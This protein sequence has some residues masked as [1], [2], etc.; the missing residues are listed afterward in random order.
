[1][2]SVSFLAVA[3][4]SQPLPGQAAPEPV[5]TVTLPAT[6]AD[7]PGYELTGSPGEGL[8]F[9]VKNFPLEDGPAVDAMIASQ[10]VLRCAPKIAF[11]ADYRSMPGNITVKGKTV[12]GIVRYERTALCV[13]PMKPIEPAPANFHPTGDDDSKLVS[14]FNAY[15]DA[16]DAGDVDALMPL[17]DY[18]P[19]PRKMLLQEMSDYKLQYGNQRRIV[20]KTSWYP[21]PPELHNGIFGEVLFSQPMSNTKMLCGAAMFYKR[22]D[23]DFVLSRILTVPIDR[24]SKGVMEDRTSCS[25]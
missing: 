24:P 14:T 12:V 8:S 20:L 23:H 13:E 15:F 10:A 2:R 19:F 1:M 21:N 9:V 4:V 11:P 16:F 7:L 25:R 18:P 6:V 5:Q 17:R 22:A 3:I